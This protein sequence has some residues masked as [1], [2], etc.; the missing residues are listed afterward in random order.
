MLDLF[1]FLLEGGHDGSRIVG[2]RG[3]GFLFS[4]WRLDKKGKDRRDYYVLIKHN[5]EH[6]DIFLYPSSLSGIYRVDKSILSTRA[7]SISASSSFIRA[8]PLK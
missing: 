8:S 6:R 1:L 2:G 5:G 7:T 4:H 3:K